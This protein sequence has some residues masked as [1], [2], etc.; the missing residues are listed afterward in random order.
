[1]TL[2]EHHRCHGGTYESLKEAQRQQTAGL[3]PPSSPQPPNS[4][5]NSVRSAAGA[6]PRAHLPARQSASCARPGTTRRMCPH[7]LRQPPGARGRVP[8]HPSDAKAR[9]P[10]PQVKR[11]NRDRAAGTPQPPAPIWRAQKGHAPRLS[12]PRGTIRKDSHPVR[13]TRVAW[14]ALKKKKGSKAPETVASPSPS[15]DAG[16]PPGDAQKTRRVQSRL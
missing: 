2:A 4:G 13:S 12:P 5:S 3:W 1:M 10:G 11:H 15:S 7:Q 8:P 16:P 6:C 9:P 14:S